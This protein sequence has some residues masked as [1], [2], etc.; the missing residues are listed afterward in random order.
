[1]DRSLFRLQVEIIIEI[2][3]TGQEKER[4]RNRLSRFFMIPGPDRIDPK[5]YL[6]GSGRK[7]NSMHPIKTA[8]IYIS[9]IALLSTVSDCLW[10]DISLPS[11][12]DSH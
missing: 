2:E 10:A 9:L 4:L 8:V 6:P 11:I 7:E 1:M 3:R 5:P 12:L